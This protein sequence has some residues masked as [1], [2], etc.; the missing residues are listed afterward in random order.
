MGADFFVFEKQARL[1]WNTRKCQCLDGK[2]LPCRQSR[3]RV[4]RVQVQT[5]DTKLSQLRMLRD[6]K[7][8]KTMPVRDHD[9][10]ADPRKSYI[11]VIQHRL[12]KPSRFIRP[13]VRAGCDAYMRGFLVTDGCIKVFPTN[14][15]PFVE[16]ASVSWLDV[17][18]QER[19]VSLEVIECPP[20]ELPRRGHLY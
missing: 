10:N 1:R 6:S 16:I 15:E 4:G 9:R 13:H 11:L 12:S 2:D 8:R 5:G 17:R 7:S 14:F 18:S 3:L 19:L 20:S